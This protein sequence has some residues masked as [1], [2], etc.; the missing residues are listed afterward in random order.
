[1]VSSSFIHLFKHYKGVVVSQLKP[2]M[3]ISWSSRCRSDFHT[4]EWS[5]PRPSTW[6]RGKW[7]GIRELKGFK[8]DAEAAL[9]PGSLTSPSQ[10]PGTNSVGPPPARDLWLH[11][12]RRHDSREINQSNGIYC[13]LMKVY[14]TA[15]SWNANAFVFM[16]KG[17]VQLY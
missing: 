15:Q 8:G 12:R 6:R 16:E 11:V 2:E 14:Q 3:K 17:K 7:F 9:E 5:R 1:M 4:S 10:Y 13:H